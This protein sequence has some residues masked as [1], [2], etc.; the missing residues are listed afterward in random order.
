VPRAERPL[1][2]DGTALTE[3]ATDL[4]SLRKKAGS[5]SYR[6]LARLAHFSSST[7]SD[8][9]GGKK[10][11]S[12][13]VTLAYVRACEG[14]VEEWERRWHT[15][16]IE[17]EPATAAGDGDGSDGT[18]A[19]YA[20]LAAY[21][22]E[23][24]EWFHGREAL[25]EE[26]T[27]RVAAQRFVTV[28]G[29][30][31]AG[32]SS[33]LRAG[34]APRLTA[35][36]STVL[37]LFTPGAHPVEECAIQFARLLGTTPGTVMA[38]LATDSRGLHRLV[39]QTLGGEPA[40]TQMVLAIDQFEE[41]FTL[42]RDA[43]ERSRFIAV[44]VGAVQAG[45]TRCR[46]VLGVRADFY[47]HCLFDPDL[48]AMLGDGHLPVGPM[49]AEELRH[50]IVAPARQA[51]CT[52]ENALLATLIAQA[53]GNEGMLPLLSHA[54]LQTW[55]HRQGN[56]LTLA[57]YQ[58]TGGLDGALTKTA[59]HVYTSLDN[60]GQQHIVR[61]LFLRLVEL[62]E[63]TQDTKRRVHRDELDQD[64]DT[65]LDKL[66]AARLI[67]LSEHSIEIT[68]EA[69]IGAWPRLR[70]WLVHDREGQRVHR[71]LTE[72]TATWTE[73]NHDPSTL[74]RGA[75]LATIKEWAHDRDR[76]NLAEQAFLDASVAADEH[77]RATA[78]RRV[79]VLRGLVVGLVVLLV[80]ASTAAV[81]ATNSERAA[82]RQRNIAVALNAVRDANELIN[83]NPALAAH[84]SL[85]AYRLHPSQTTRESL[86]AASAAATAIPI[87]ATSPFA[88]IVPNGDLVAVGDREQDTIVL[89][90]VSDTAITEVARIHGGTMQPTF[91]PD[92]RTVA[93]FD[94]NAVVRLW[95]I[96]DP[97]NP[98]RAAALPEKAK[99]R[100]FSPDGSLLVT[101]DITNAQP[102]PNGPPFGWT[103]GRASRLWDVS[104]LDQPQ[105][106]AILP[107]ASAELFAFGDHGDVLATIDMGENKTSKQTL[108][109]DISAPETPRL[110]ARVNVR[111]RAESA[112]AVFVDNDRTLI[113]GNLAGNFSLWDVNALNSPRPVAEIQSSEGASNVVAA[114]PDRRRLAT[115][116]GEDEVILWDISA[117]TAPEKVME[118]QRVEST[119]TDLIF[120][121]HHATL[122]AIAIKAG[123]ADSPSPW[124]INLT[125]WH[126]NPEDSAAAV[127]AHVSP[128]LTESDWRKHFIDVPYQ[129][130]CG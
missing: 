68:H 28:V 95:D 37:V 104:D 97:A 6:E 85:V 35:A 93:T 62:G 101:T 99:D 110:A 45:G 36:G 46:V 114:S 51:E 41:V 5:P 40:E 7:L 123:D 16:V 49:S 107:N 115:S 17:S 108:L 76:T 57:A 19:P 129:P 96:T 52:V 27:R 124:A 94:Q 90:R 69:L 64:A 12:L 15:L 32:K 25:T 58:R 122:Q 59:E 117:P 42:C 47:N 128:R 77:E 125:T 63:G 60:N 21:Q 53:T 61:D 11:P 82:T 103:N 79:R 70:A 126:L 78:L 83:A 4:R 119:L 118:L 23:D 2:S 31:G 48:A 55:R 50:A 18:R 39:R 111:E 92:S 72:A 38:E 24:A 56:A 43:A 86:A 81:Y 98:R 74:L 34:L 130:P 75:R 116:N 87:G 54:L 3:F 102:D 1:E 105:Q 22:V 30:S 80:A 44:L 65:V 29:P 113:T 109:W 8:A 20:G 100:Q 89:S 121:P 10:V 73:H 106:L 88:S 112:A 33:L 91:S 127:C 67:V 71:K 66:A 26:L 14:D 9:A 13:A 84:L 120:N